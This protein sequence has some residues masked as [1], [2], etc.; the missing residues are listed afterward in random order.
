MPPS[1]IVRSFLDLA[2]TIFSII[3]SGFA[4]TY[5]LVGPGEYDPKGILNKLFYYDVPTLKAANTDY[6]QVVGE[7]KKGDE[8][9]DDDDDESNQSGD[10]DDE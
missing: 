1:D 8:D 9:D 3:G 10:S 2:T 4:L 5:I 7:K 6:A